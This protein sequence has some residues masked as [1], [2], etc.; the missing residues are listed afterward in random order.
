[1]PKKGE[2]LTGRQKICPVCGKEF[3]ACGDWSFKKTDNVT[4]SKIYYCSWSC[5]RKTERPVEQQEVSVQQR[6]RCLICGRTEPEID[7]RYAAE[8]IR[9]G[10]CEACR[11]AV[12]F[13]RRF[14][15]D[16]VRRNGK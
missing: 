5:L 6:Q 16:M 13:A 12:L 4:K 15:E 1:M 3:Y 14:L 8:E 2:P 11:E 10:V 7:Y 9:D